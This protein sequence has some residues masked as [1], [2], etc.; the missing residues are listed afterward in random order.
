MELNN[1]RNEKEIDY[2]TKTMKEN[3]EIIKKLESGVR[4][5]NN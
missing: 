2:K 4:I 3:A 5:L 1:A